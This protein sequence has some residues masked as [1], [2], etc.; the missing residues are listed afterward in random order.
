MLYGALI[1]VIVVLILERLTNNKEIE[2][3]TND[4][5]WIL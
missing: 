3:P 1:F 2:K 4:I 5:R